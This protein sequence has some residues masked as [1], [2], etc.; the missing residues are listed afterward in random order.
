MSV[1]RTINEVNYADSRRTVM[2]LGCGRGGTSALAGG[3]RELGVE[4]P[5]AHPLKHEWSPVGSAGTPDLRAIKRTIEQIDQEHSIWGWKSPRD[6][7]LAEQ[8]LP[9]VT[10]PIIFIVIRNIVDISES[11]MRHSNI[12][13][14]IG[15]NEAIRAYESV[16]KFII[17]TTYP[18]VIVSYEK[19]LNNPTTFFE[20]ASAWSGIDA[21]SEKIKAAVDF[22]SGA[23]TYKKVSL[24]LRDLSFSQVEL[25]RDQINSY[26]TTYPAFI[27]AYAQSV[28]ATELDIKNLYVQLKHQRDKLFVAAKERCDKIGV[29]LDPNIIY[30][31]AALNR[32]VFAEVLDLRLTYEHPKLCDDS[33]PAIE[34]VGSNQ[35]DNIP[36]SQTVAK[37]DYELARLYHESYLKARQN[38]IEIKKQRQKLQLEINDIIEKQLMIA[39]VK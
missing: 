28:S 25:D 20:F 23:V 33:Q 18:T 38:F 1:F 19:L 21:G 31:F 4:M 30:Q 29:D 35:F 13:F 17:E 26:R 10:N 12:E 32:N 16:G 11:M 9:I 27:S 6:V 3:L 14:E 15:F 37:E 5:N 7:F 39:E 36:A 34:I 22:V 2:V 24:E 8:I